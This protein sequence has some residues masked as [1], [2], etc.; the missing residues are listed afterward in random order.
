MVVSVGHWLLC[1]WWYYRFGRNFQFYSRLL[2]AA[3]SLRFSNRDGKGN[4]FGAPPCVR[5][6][7]QKVVDAH[8]NRFN[9]KNRSKYRTIN[10]QRSITVKST[11]LP[12][13]KIVLF[14]L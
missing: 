13:V 3:E 12:A 5:R 6:S 11:K 2:V 14:Y 10:D 4:P 9:F 1:T 7:K 8:H